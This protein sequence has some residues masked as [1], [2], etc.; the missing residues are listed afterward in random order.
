MPTVAYSSIYNAY[1][2][3]YNGIIQHMEG[4]QKMTYYAV[5]SFTVKC[6]ARNEA[7]A[8]KIFKEFESTDDFES[9]DVFHL[10]KRI[11]T[12]QEYIQKLAGNTEG[13]EVKQN[14]T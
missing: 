12:E 13:K 4:A 3:R 6:E 11:Y 10:F 5:Y 7:Q 14:E 9:T 2:G 1:I 8:R